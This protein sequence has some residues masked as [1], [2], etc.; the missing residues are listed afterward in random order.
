MVSVVIFITEGTSGCMSEIRPLIA[1]EVANVH[2]LWYQSIK[3]NG[4]F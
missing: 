2:Y 1:R 3:K 4:S